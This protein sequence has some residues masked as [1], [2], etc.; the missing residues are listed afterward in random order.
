MRTFG[1]DV[2]H[3]EGTIDWEAAAPAIGFVYS[4]CTDGVKFI[5]NQFNNNLS[6]CSRVGLPHAP[7]HYFQPLLDPTAQAEHF[8]GTAGINYK[9][10]IVDVE[11]RV[12]DPKIVLK[13]HTFLERVEKLTGIMPAI[14][15]SAGYWND[16]IQPRPS[17]AGS[18]D[19][20]IAHYTSAHTP[21][22]P[23]GWTQHVIWQFSDFWNIPGGDAVVDANWFNGNLEQCRQWFGNY[24]PGLLPHFSL[25]KGEA[26]EAQCSLQ[27]TGGGLQMRSLFENLHIRQSPKMNARVTGKL[28][29]GEIVDVEQLGGN[30]AW[31]RHE[32]GWS[33]VEIEGYRYMS[34]VTN[35]EANS[36]GMEVVK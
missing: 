25:H 32:R 14:Y 24:K 12:R 1:I 35:T 7:Y 26:E 21:L 17:W 34:V 4:K 19:L 16:Y 11:A 2:S 13:L 3:W 23:H 29:K 8:I 36:R 20:I 22:L 18:Y 28:A 33:A 15:T 27:M 9:R 5:D 6:G 31:I 30:D 10:Y